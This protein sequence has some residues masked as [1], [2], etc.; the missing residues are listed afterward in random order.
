[1]TRINT[2][3]SAMVARTALDRT[4]TDL[5][6]RLQRLSTGLKINRGADDPAGLIVS[7]RLRGEISGIGQAVDNIE[8]ASNVIATTESALQ[9]INDLLVSIKGLTVEAA[10]TGAFSKQ[11][12]AANQ[13]QIDSAVESITRISNTASFAGLKLLNGSLD[14]LTSGVT[15]SQISDV[16]IKGANFGLNDSIPISV[17]VLQSAERASLFLSGNGTGAWG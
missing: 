3:V 17:E 12:I 4:N 1:M 8:R 7:E 13:L 16:S 15:A 9:E 2:N 11:E 5:S 10:N 14:Y 6:T